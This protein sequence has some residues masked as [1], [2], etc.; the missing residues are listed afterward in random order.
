MTPPSFNASFR[1]PRLSFVANNCEPFTAS[2]LVA[3][4]S[5]AFTFVS[6]VP[7]LPAS[8]T[9]SRF[10]VPSVLLSY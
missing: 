7:D 8:V 2:V 3:D 1:S 9:D 5:A 6:F 10:A 4:S